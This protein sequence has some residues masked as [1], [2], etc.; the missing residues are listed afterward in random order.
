MSC[1]NRP[2]AWCASWGR[3]QNADAS[4]LISVSW[5][6]DYVYPPGHPSLGT[7][8]MQGRRNKPI[9]VDPRSVQAVA[10]SCFPGT[11]LLLGGRSTRSGFRAIRIWP[12]CM[13]AVRHLSEALRCSRRNHSHGYVP[14]ASCRLPSGM[15]HALRAPSLPL[16]PRR[17]MASVM[18]RSRSVRAPAGPSEA[19]IGGAVTTAWNAAASG[20]SE[21]AARTGCCAAASTHKSSPCRTWV[22]YGHR[23]REVVQRASSAAAKSSGAGRPDDAGDNAD[24]V[25]APW[26]PGNGWLG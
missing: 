5:R 14:E 13:R 7:S 4:A 1:G 10:V 18:A 2:T 17:F 26:P 3:F 24:G 19:E 22:G 15:P 16:G 25:L 20:R 8:W 21:H 12:S 6:R 11:W 9:A 23:S